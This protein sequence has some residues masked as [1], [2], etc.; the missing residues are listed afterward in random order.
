MS[1]NKR[2]EQKK[3]REKAIK[4]AKRAKSI[5]WVVIVVC[6]LAVVGLVGWAVAEKIVTNVKPVA[7]FSAGLNSDGTIKD[8]RA[9][10]YVDLCD[11]K[12]LTINRSELEVSDEE[13]K[14]YIEQVRKSFPEDV[15]DPSITIK[16]GDTI[17]FDYLGKM[18]GVP[19][20]GGSTNGQ[21]TDA[22]MDNP[23]GFI[24]GFTE[25]II[26][27]NVGE[28]FDIYVT[29]PDNYTAELAGKDAVFTITINSYVDTAPEFNDAFVEKNLSEIALTADG[30]EKYYKE[31]KFQQALY[32]Y[33]QK[34]V[35]DNS[36]V[37]DYP[38]EYLNILKGQ[39][40]YDDEQSYEAENNTA[41]QNS[42]K[43]KYS[44]FNAYIGGMSD[45]EYSAF[46]SQKATKQA[47]SDLIYQAILEDAGITIGS[48]DV[49]EYL[50]SIGLDESYYSSS[51]NTY[52]RGYVYHQ[53]MVYT[54]IKYL[55][56]VVNV[57]E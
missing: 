23:G 25:Q 38:K 35:I 36:T 29:F 18:D 52:G 28:T 54:V 55:A 13:Y 4:Q 14:S 50:V 22:V 26:G 48:E 49:A 3:N 11:Y 20:D 31:I 21:G 37:K 57:V 44:S 16:E 32:T 15:T 34:Y 39:L 9:L 7:D 10:D 47:D 12:N 5:K 24:P 51:V 27:H 8:V 6:C 2:T 33:M 19:F 43:P 46:L 1:D 53:G 30:F 56:D 17:N 41:I 40:K 45:K 42:G